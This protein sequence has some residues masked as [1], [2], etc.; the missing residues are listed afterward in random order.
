MPTLQCDVL[1]V[2]SGA[3]GLSTAITAKKHGLDVVV[4]EKEEHFGGTTA[5]SGGVLWIPGNHLA[6]ATGVQ[7]SREAARTYL[8]NEAGAFFDDRAADALLEYGPE[9]LEFFERETEVKF[10]PTLYPDYHPTLPGGVDIGRSVL[11]APYDIRRLGEDMA[12]LRPPLETI[13]FIGMMFNSSNA[14]LKHFFN[15][16]KSLTS[17][18]YVTKRLATHLKELLLYRRGINVTSGNALAARLAQSALDLGIPIHTRTPA[19]E[20][21]LENGRVIGALVRGPQGTQRIEARR[22]VVLASGG[23]SHDLARIHQAYPH[24]RRGGEHLSPVPVGN[25]G[26]GAYLAESVGGKLELRFP[27]AAAWMPVSRVPLGKGRH[28]VFPHLLDRYKPG[29]IGVL[30]DGR[31]FTNESESYHDVGAAL[32][33]ACE[34]QRETVM[35]LVCDRTAIGKYGL[36]YAKPSPMP[37]RPLIR[38]GYLLKGATLAELAQQAGIDPRGLEETVCQYNLGA[39]RGVDNE[40]GRGTTAFNRYL[41]DPE[42]RPNPCVAPIGK[43]PYYAVK[44]VMGDLGTFDGLRTSLE[45]EVLGEGGAAIPGLYAVGN[46]RASVMGGNYPGAGITLGPIMTFGYL[47]GRH[48][49]RAEALQPATRYREAV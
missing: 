8:R 33:Q 27:E 41:A 26:D 46:D 22:G 24:L 23:F 40:F 12:R 11:A 15:A 13:T 30:R 28:G 43:G 37:L 5:F 18:V 19:S 32:I 25:T 21:L 17:F 7:D 47:T 36:G 6:R 31:R 9:M 4:V 14:D 20:L 45:G 16:T 2:G 49:A 42:H 1:V 10:V 38:S 29:V 44:V 48:L 34:G 3:G 35:W 39:E